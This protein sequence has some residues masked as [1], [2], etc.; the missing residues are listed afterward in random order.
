MEP[1]K[2]VRRDHNTPNKTSM[3]NIGLV[4]ASNMAKTMASH[5]NNTRSHTDNLATPSRNS[6][7]KAMARGPK[8][9]TIK[10]NT[11]NHTQ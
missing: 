7:H 1:N 6:Q 2:W 4:S 10:S 8:E 5:D 11:A 3:A 9:I